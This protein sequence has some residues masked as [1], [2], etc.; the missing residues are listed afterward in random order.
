VALWLGVRLMPGMTLTGRGLHIVA[1]DNIPMLKELARD[2]LVIKATR[3]DTI[4]GL[5]N[6]MDAAVAAAPKL[7]VRL[8]VMEGKKDPIIPHAATR[9][10]LRALPKDPDDRRSLAL[11]RHGYHMLFRDLD[12]ATVIADAAGWMLDPGAPLISGADRGAAQTLRLGSGHAP[13]V[14]G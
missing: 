14:G 7:E 10:F 1:S 3:I 2:P 9:R 12:G 4:D 6:L 13:A 8:L 11:Y 5:V